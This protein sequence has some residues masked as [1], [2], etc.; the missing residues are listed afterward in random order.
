MA[1]IYLFSRYQDLVSRDV[2]Q[3]KRTGNKNGCPQQAIRSN[4]T[5][6]TIGGNE[7]YRDISQ[8]QRRCQFGNSRPRVH[9]RAVHVESD[10]CVSRDGNRLG[11]MFGQA[12]N[13][14]LKDGGSPG[15]VADDG[16]LDRGNADVEEAM[17]MVFD[18]PPP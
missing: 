6:H 12:L 9:V 8:C 15:R 18:S 11:L 5:A 4:S 17:A 10:V 2:E 16:A 1:P 3:P 13:G 7:K 14:R